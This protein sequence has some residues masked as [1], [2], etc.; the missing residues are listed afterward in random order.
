M[1]C[2]IAGN[3]VGG[4]QFAAAGCAAGQAGRAGTAAALPR[5]AAEPRGHLPRRAAGRVERAGDRR[6]AGA[7]VGEAD[8][9]R[10]YRDADLGLEVAC[11]LEVV[12]PGGEDRAAGLADPR[13]VRGAPVRTG[14]AERA[15]AG[16]RR[17]TRRGAQS[18]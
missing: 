14:Q 8:P 17:A 5:V 7:G 18:G 11:T 2:Q 6:A 12:V 9:D 4:K 1:T 16:P 10:A 3:P 15:V 13:R